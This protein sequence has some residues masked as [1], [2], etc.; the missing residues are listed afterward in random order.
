MLSAL[1]AHSR[2]LFRWL[3]FNNTDLFSCT[4]IKILQA[5]VAFQPALAMIVCSQEEYE[6]RIA[7]LQSDQ[8]VATTQII[9][10]A[11]PD[12]FF[13]IFGETADSLHMVLSRSRSQALNDT[14]CFVGQGRSRLAVFLQGFDMGLNSFADGYIFH[15][16]SKAFYDFRQAIRSSR[17]IRTPI[18]VSILWR[19]PFSLER[20][21]SG[22]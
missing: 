8:A 4:S 18:L 19:N 9:F 6:N 14:F 15:A 16:N 20:M 2:N 13:P 5:T 11:I 12:P 17:I 10:P 21:S 1:F 22:L 7:K 3:L